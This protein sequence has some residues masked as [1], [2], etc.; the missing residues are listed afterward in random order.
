MTK[1]TSLRNKT[2]N[3]VG[4]SFID[5]FAGQIVSFIVGLVLARLL[6]PEEY[7][8]IGIITIFIVVFNSII[9]SGFSSALIRKPD[10]NS[11]DYNTVFFINLLLSILLSI[12]MF[13][14]APLI[15]QFFDRVELLSLTRVMSIILVINAL[16]IIPNVIL[17][18][19][20]NF[21]IKT[22][23]SI[24]SSLVSGIVGITMALSNLG[25][26]SLVGQQLS[27]QTLS[28][29]LLW[30]YTQ[31]KP[32]FSISIKSFKELFGFSWKLLISTIIDK[33]WSQIY[34][35]IIGKYYS[36]AILGHFT[37]S[38]NFTSLFSTNIDS[39]V[40]RVS[41]PVLSSI[42][43]DKS[44]LKYGYKKIIK[45]SMLLTFTLMFGLAAVAKPMI[46]V[47]IGER[48]LPCVP[49]IQIL[50]ISSS[51]YPLHSL[52]L[53]MLQIQGRSDLFLKLE[54][55]KKFISIGPLIVGI[56]IDIYWMLLGG[57]ITG[58]FAYYLNS[59]YSGIFLN[60]NIKEQIKD[61][62]PSFVVAITMALIVFAISF[63]PIN[64]FILFPLQL[65][66][67]ALV[68]IGISEVLRL[69]EYLEIKSIIFPIITRKFIKQ[70]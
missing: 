22:K 12:L 57:V 39:V 10:A 51:L 53:N 45:V 43:N 48:W 59:Y 1:E 19:D 61:I 24:I 44:R 3:G 9:D 42:Q 58:L 70:R 4:W 56:F 69:P 62:L 55:I 29:I 8:L 26:W 40:Q 32:R 36:P 60:Y 65:L 67:G 68:I 37:R 34:Q 63:I 52:N 17:S 54:I 6:S 41:Y 27:R 5:S 35:V 15:A 25:V 11:T 16:A 2:I 28:S 7:G 49:F 30:V 38:I 66:V 21:K 64:H 20:I 23:V 13:F 50:C 31:W 47:L 33:V 46:L 18:K 14:G